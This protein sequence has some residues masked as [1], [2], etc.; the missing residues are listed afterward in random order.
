MCLQGSLLPQGS[1]RCT[2]SQLGY[3]SLDLGISNELQLLLSHPVHCCGTLSREDQV[4]VIAYDLVPVQVGITGSRGVVERR[5]VRLVAG[6]LR[7]GVGC[8]KA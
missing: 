6:E 3:L 2:E 1:H 7:C 4:E 8:I 5:L